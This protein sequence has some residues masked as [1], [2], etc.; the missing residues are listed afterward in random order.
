MSG[1]P[2]GIVAVAIILLLYVKWPEY[3]KGI[4]H[5]LT[6]YSTLQPCDIE[7]H[8]KA[9]ATFA[10]ILMRVNIRIGRAAYR[11]FEVISVGS[12]ILFLYFLWILSLWLFD[13]VLIV[14]GQ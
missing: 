6:R 2:L 1:C 3:G 13:C 11:Y 9:R 7:F 14:L 8:D 10:S 5:C 4:W 12:V